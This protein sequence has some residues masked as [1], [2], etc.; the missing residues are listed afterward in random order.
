MSR[1]LYKVLF[2]KR[3]NETY[4]KLGINQQELNRLCE[5]NVNQISRYERGM[6]VPSLE[7][8]AKIA[9]ILDVSLDYLVGLSDDP[10]GQVSLQTSI[11]MNA[12]T[13]TG[14]AR[15]GV[16]RLSK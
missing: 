4:E 3:L 8:A 13:W 2:Q 10:H 7:I 9:N 15:L 6:Q 11:Y 12:R 14:I 5:M 16:E 1:A